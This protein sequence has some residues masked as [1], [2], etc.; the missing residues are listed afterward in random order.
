MGCRRLN[1]L[2]LTHYDKDH[3]SGV[4][5]LLARM[6]VDTLLVPEA[7]DDAGLQGA[8]LSAAREHG[9][10]VRFITE[11]ERLDFGRGTLT[12]LPSLGDTG[13]NERGLAILASSGDKDFLITGDMNSVTEAKLLES[14]D[15]PD[16]EGLVAGHHGSKYATSQALL[17][18]LTP[19]TACISVGSNSYGH[20][21]EETLLRLARQGCDIYRTDLHGTIHLAWN[22]EETHG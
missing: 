1:W 8:V 13:D 14:Y 5:G 17:E 22:Q 15:L 9:T 3:V 6:K 7:E 19:E 18:A 12:I 16:I 21:T 4:T 2:V 10:E 20:P 11:E